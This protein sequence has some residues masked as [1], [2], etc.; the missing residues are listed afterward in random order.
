[1]SQEAAL[2]AKI[3]DRSAA[4][5]IVGLGYVRL[6]LLLAATAKGYRVLGFDIDGLR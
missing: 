5:G 2:K 3:D 4:V 6:P 1:M